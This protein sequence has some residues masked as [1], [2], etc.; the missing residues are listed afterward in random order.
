M[1]EPLAEPLLAPVE[2]RGCISEAP[3][4]GTRRAGPPGG[5]RDRRRGR[6]SLHGPVAMVVGGVAAEDPQPQFG[7]P[8]AGP[9]VS[10]SCGRCR[11][12]W[13]ASPK[14]YGNSGA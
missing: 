2:D 7:Q 11:A 4:G 9:L 3:W 6:G 8:S 5:A 1:G 14:P 12:R 10:G 13:Y